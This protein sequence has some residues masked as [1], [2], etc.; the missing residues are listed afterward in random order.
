MANYS[1]LFKKIITSFIHI[2][3]L[4]PIS[5]V[6]ILYFSNLDKNKFKMLSGITIKTITSGEE[7]MQNTAG[8]E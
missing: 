1:S 6:Q 4:L 7:V 3:Q 5:A 8:D 2:P